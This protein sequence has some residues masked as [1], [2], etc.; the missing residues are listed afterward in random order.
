MVP[1]ESKIRTAKILILGTADAGKSTL[2]R[3]MRKLHGREFESL[4]MA[5]FK[6]VIRLSCIEYL[7]TIVNKFL[8][9]EQT[10]KSYHGACENFL[11]HYRSISDPDNEFIDKAL[12]IWR[13]GALQSYITKTIHWESYGTELKDIAS[14]LSHINGNKAQAIQMSFDGQRIYSDNPINHFLKCFE[15]IMETDYQPNL[16]DILN[17]RVPTS[18]TFKKV[19]E[20]NVT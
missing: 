4:E 3:H 15:R 2:I 11:E 5:H 14:E 8:K 18:G 20:N 1:V 7:V 12:N 16:E 6:K 19:I 17:L 10:T 9:D 13:V